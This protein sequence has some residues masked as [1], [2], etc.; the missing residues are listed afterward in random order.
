MNITIINHGPSTV[1][2]MAAKTRE[3]TVLRPGASVTLRSV[4]ALVSEHSLVTPAP[5]ARRGRKPREA[6][7]PAQPEHGAAAAEAAR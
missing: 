1:S 4:A 7:V 6:A 2:A 5:A 3:P